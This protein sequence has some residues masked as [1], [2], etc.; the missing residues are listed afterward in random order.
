MAEDD[1]AILERI[2][3]QLEYAQRADEDACSVFLAEM[4]KEFQ[5]KK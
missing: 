5:S 1:D 3:R 2:W 4:E